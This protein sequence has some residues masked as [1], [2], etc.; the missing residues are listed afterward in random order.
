MTA[1]N[2][3]YDDGE[4]EDVLG[5]GALLRRRISP[6]GD[7]AERPQIGQEVTLRLLGRLQAPPNTVF[8]DERCLT[9]RVGEGNFVTG[10]DLA[11]RLMTLGEVARLRLQARF[12]YGQAG[13]SSLGIP[14][15]ADVEYEVALLDLGKH[16]GPDPTVASVSERLADS[17]DFAEKAK[18][19]WVSGNFFS[20]LD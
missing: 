8:C 12:A 7:G 20:K 4:W 17:A 11:L 2:S 14:A 16:R 6:G 13:D 1:E 10:L 5:S 3:P 9:K 15:D 18:A 19:L